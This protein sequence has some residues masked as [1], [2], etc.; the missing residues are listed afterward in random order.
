MGKCKG[1]KMQ[2]NCP[3]CKGVRMVENE[4]AKGASMKGAYMD[5]GAYMAV[6]FTKKFC[7][8]Y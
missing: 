4:M 1:A 2:C 6:P 7:K 3:M 5:K 8:G